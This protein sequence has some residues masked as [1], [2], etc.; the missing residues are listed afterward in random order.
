MNNPLNISLQIDR[1]QVVWRQIADQMRSKIMSGELPAGAKLPSTAELAKLAD[2]DV[3]TIHR[4][5]TDLVREGLIT[6]ARKVGTYVTERKSL[7]SPIGI[8]YSQNI[9][10]ERSDLFLHC[11][12]GELQRLAHDKGI[13]TR[14][15]V[16]NRPRK[17]Q[18]TTLPELETAARERSIVGLVSTVADPTHLAWLDKLPV[19][20]AYNGATQPSSAKWNIPQMIDLALNSLKKQGCRSVGLITHIRD[21]N[22][23]FYD[24]LR[25]KSAELGLEI[26]EEWLLRPGEYVEAA[27]SGY[28]YGYDYFNELWAQAERPDGLLVY[29]DVVARGV[30]MAAVAHQ[31][32]TQELKLMLH[33]NDEID[34]FCPLP[35]TFVVSSAR[36]NA[37][38]LLKQLDDQFHGRT[39][40]PIL[41]QFKLSGVGAEPA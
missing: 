17:D 2:T 26:R 34:L 20:V 18:T 5:L 27:T 41:L 28:K 31:V 38:A 15:L 16:D 21:G 3:K 25:A 10:A 8:Y 19:S 29:P 36:D 14:I 24:H 22:T 33:K 39:P 9:P 30:I 1:P 7:M 4:A 35:A 32:N 37:A 40:Q 13:A 11:L 12:H 23:L 6:R